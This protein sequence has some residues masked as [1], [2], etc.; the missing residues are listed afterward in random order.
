MH[1]TRDFMLP[2]VVVLVRLLHWPDGPVVDVQQ[3][4]HGSCRGRGE[5]GCNNQDIMWEVI[6]E[7]RII[8]VLATT[9]D[10]NICFGSMWWIALEKLIEL[11]W[12]ELR[13]WLCLA[14]ARDEC[15]WAEQRGVHAE[16]HWWITSRRRVCTLHSHIK[17]SGLRHHE[18]IFT[19]VSA[20][21]PRRLP[22][23]SIR[24]LSTTSVFSFPSTKH[25]AAFSFQSITSGTSAAKNIWNGYY[26]W[27]DSF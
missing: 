21:K 5:M 13:G 7:R 27:R 14:A 10:Y 1:V 11:S 6:L 17:A 16:L 18:A 22:Q 25:S 4:L 26:Y 15:G 23:T 8:N 20:E 2:E 9:T 19:T 12:G 24:S 3:L